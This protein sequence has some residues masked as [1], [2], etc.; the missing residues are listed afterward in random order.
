MNTENTWYFNS[1]AHNKEKYIE[2]SQR[3][4]ACYPQGKSSQNDS[5]FLSETIQAREWK[6]FFNYLMKRNVTRILY[7]EEISF[8]NQ[9]EIKNFKWRETKILLP[10][11]LL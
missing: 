9:R 2:S 4:M 11:D 7:S 1:K 8:M 10:A 5:E 6:I 3:K